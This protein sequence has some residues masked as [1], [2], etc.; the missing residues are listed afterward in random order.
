MENDILKIGEVTEVRGQRIRAKVYKD[1]NT[2]NLNYDGNIIKNVVVGGFVKVKKGFLDIIG[3]IE[4]EYINENSFN[5]KQFTEKQDCGER[6][7]E[8]SV[9]GSICND[10]MFKRGL[11]ELPLISNYV[12]ILSEREVQKVFAFNDE[13]KPRIPIGNIIAY[14][15]YKLKLC[16]QDL[17]G[18]HIG[19]FGNT[20]SGKSNTLAKVYTELFK[21]YEEFNNFRSNSKFILIDFNGE[22]T[23]T[24]SNTNRTIYA[25]STRR[26]G[27]CFPLQVE[28]L[29]GLEFWA[30]I[31]EATE[32]T[33]QPFLKKALHLFEKI[34]Q[35]P[36]R[37]AETIVEHTSIMLNKLFD[38]K[39]KW[40]ILK[41]YYEEILIL[42]FNN[43]REGVSNL[44]SVLAY[45]STTGNF[46]LTQAP[47]VYFNSL[48]Q[49]YGNPLV[50]GLQGSIITQNSVFSNQ[51]PIDYWALFEFVI[52]YCYI[53]DLSK[54]FIIEEHIA[55]M[56]KR[57]DNRLKDIRKVFVVSNRETN[58]NLNIIS[59][60]DVNIHMRKIIPM[61]ICKNA[62]DKH[63]MD[64]NGKVLYMIID[65]AHNI[66]S[67]ESE[68]ESSIWKDYRLE[69][70][71]E[72][73]KEGR[74][75]GVFLTIASQRP[76]DISDTIISQL[77]NYFLHRLVNNED[78]KAIGKT[79]SFLDNA[80]FEMIPILP[81]G[82][83]I[84]TGTAS[85]FPVLVQVDILEESL[86]PKSQTVGLNEL[87]IDNVE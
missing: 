35:D 43:I 55:P 68:R 44:F 83:C 64:S 65:E 69:V 76:S 86:Q 4:G 45:N 9:V 46:Y 41:K 11:S 81:Q 1:K 85:N 77:H 8:I 47:V 71:E 63:K 14:E 84:F 19:I 73:I 50:R 7:I 80:S 6:V 25:L 53:Q 20:G 40:H 30:I 18:S 37:I 87:W 15:N 57:L 82:A 42:G 58:K 61:V 51:T 23:R 75:F 5:Y 21:K 48:Q 3:K 12:Y 16:V 28:Y 59:L 72:I 24:I 56:L 52:K 31:L 62:Y 2:S 27:D 79:V 38:Q 32:K 33:Q 34:V 54:G 39:E 29:Q 49:F 36:D 67:K 17:F 10:G 66:L 22:Y 78:I 74:K 26:Q 60:I 70:F 13:S